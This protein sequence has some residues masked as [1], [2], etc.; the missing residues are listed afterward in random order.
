M[1]VA[2]L[3]ARTQI[4]E[5]VPQ[6]LPGAGRVDDG[7]GNEGLCYCHLQPPKLDAQPGRRRARIASAAISIT[8]LFSRGSADWYWLDGVEP[9]RTLLTFE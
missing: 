9:A 6:G 1:S 7:G 5:G 8:S 4:L 2:G 3:N